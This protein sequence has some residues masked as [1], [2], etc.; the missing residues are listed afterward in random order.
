M[1]FNY[2]NLRYINTSFF[3]LYTDKKKINKRLKREN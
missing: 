2:N 3:T 1:C